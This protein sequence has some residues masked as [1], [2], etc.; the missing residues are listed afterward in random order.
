MCGDGLTWVEASDGYVPAEAVSAG[1]QSNGEPLYV[2]RA[3]ICGSLSTGKI[4][5]S[6]NCIYVPFDGTEH[7]ISQYEV[8]VS[9]QRCKQ[10]M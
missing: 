2:G 9:Q 10:Q 6:H 3:N 5:P 7:S 4:L 1:V 8:L